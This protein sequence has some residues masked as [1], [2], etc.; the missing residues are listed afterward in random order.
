M[1]SSIGRSLSDDSLVATVRRVLI[2]ERRLLRSAAAV[3]FMME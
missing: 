2:I 1:E 3:V